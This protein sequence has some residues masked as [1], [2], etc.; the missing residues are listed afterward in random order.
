MDLWDYRNGNR[1]EVFDWSCELSATDRAALNQKLDMLERL[2]FNQAI[3]LKLLAGP[4]R[5]SGHILKLRAHGDKALRPLLCRGPHV[6]LRE[7]TLLCGAEERDSKLHPQG[8]VDKA[9]EN[10]NRVREDKERRVKH[11]RA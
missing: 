7:Y 4:I 11:E 9:I 10:R 6:P 3:S 8:A 1:N 2:D 5:H